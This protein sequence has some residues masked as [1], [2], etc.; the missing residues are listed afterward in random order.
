MFARFLILREC[1]LNKTLFISDLDG[2]LLNKKGKLSNF[3]KTT[4]NKLIHEGLNFTIATGRSPFTVKFAIS[5][6]DLKIQ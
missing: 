2:T 6:L 4:L 3:T 1:T 5:D